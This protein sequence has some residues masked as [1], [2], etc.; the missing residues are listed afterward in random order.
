MLSVVKGRYEECKG[1]GGE[2]VMRGMIRMVVLSL[3]RGLMFY[4]V[5]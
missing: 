5:F 2:E 4:I 1:R 3:V